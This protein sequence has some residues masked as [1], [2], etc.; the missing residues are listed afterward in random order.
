MA[1]LSVTVAI[2]VLV[3]VQSRSIAG[4]ST[5]YSTDFS[6]DPGWTTNNASHY[7]WDS[8]S[9]GYYQE[10][11]NGSREYAYVEISGLVPDRRWRLETDIRPISNDWAANSGVRLFD[12]DMRFGQP[13]YFGIDFARTGAGR[14]PYLLYSS[15]GDTG[16]G[17]VPF[18]GS[19]FDYGAWYHTSVE[20]NPSTSQLHSAVTRKADGS[21]LGERTVTVPGDFN[22]ASRLA[23]STIDHTYASG[24]TAIAYIDNVRLST[25]SEPATLAIP[26]TFSVSQVSAPNASNHGQIGAFRGFSTTIDEALSEDEGMVYSSK[27]LGAPS[28]MTSMDKGETINYSVGER[29]L[30]SQVA[31]L[32]A[33]VER[34]N[35]NGD[36]T[37]DE[38]DTGWAPL[39]L[40]HQ[41]GQPALER[42][43]DLTSTVQGSFQVN[44]DIS[45]L[46]MR[47]TA[48][49]SMDSYTIA[50]LVVDGSTAHGAFE[51]VRN[52]VWKPKAKAAMA[53]AGAH[54]AAMATVE[55]ILDPASEYAGEVTFDFTA[56]TA[57]GA[58]T[59]I[60]TNG[61]QQNLVGW[62][63]LA[64]RTEDLTLGAMSVSAGDVINWSADF[65]TVVETLG[66]AKV[67]AQLESYR[68]EA[69]AGGEVIGVVH[70]RDDPVGGAAA[71]QMLAV[72]AADLNG[73]GI[74]DKPT[75][76]QDLL[77]NRFLEEEIIADLAYGQAALVGAAGSVLPTSGVAMVQ[78]DGN[79]DTAGFVTKLTMPV[80]AEAMYLDYQLLSS[81]DTGISADAVLAL[82]IY[83]ESGHLSFA[84]V[85]PSDLAL[86]PLDEAA[87]TYAYGS[88]WLTAEFDLTGMDP[89]AYFVVAFDTEAVAGMDLG[90][91]LDNLRTFGRPV[92]EPATLGLLFLGGAVVLLRRKR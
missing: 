85:L 45:D 62:T 5:V 52:L 18:L 82:A 25:L 11:V 80:D 16:E 48:A 42:Q 24:A 30:Q 72:A 33:P 37:I 53:K 3:S 47:L 40:G 29:S 49:G 32:R 36:D 84:E 12:A 35:T 59:V 90:V 14:I 10:R 66:Y 1:L 78:I 43:R 87:G 20:W 56:G 75:G 55:L 65:R 68:I 91:A 27:S 23:I 19:T 6:T 51:A 74:P 64:R 2:L 4:W 67:D 26:T 81:T 89:E 34:V 76:D 63:A 73:D 39:A 54:F 22:A 15:S 61:F 71:A 38:N 86:L 8:G 13:A 57:A 28:Y 70:S 21:I 41:I 83:D 58:G 46:Q 7:H 60:T 79:A 50:S 17:Q 31:Y 44:A 69:L 92:P 77:N 9:Q 88:G